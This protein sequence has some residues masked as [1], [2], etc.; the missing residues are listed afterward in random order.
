MSLTL[1]TIP[2]KKG[3]FYKE[4]FDADHSQSLCACKVEI[5]FTRSHVKI[6]QK[7]WCDFDIHVPDLM[8]LT[9][10]ALYLYVTSTLL[11]L[12]H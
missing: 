11:F 2:F 5:T 8:S 12:T 7:A 10:A 6:Y 3:W 4:K 1:V 9:M